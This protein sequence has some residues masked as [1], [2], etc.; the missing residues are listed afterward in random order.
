MNQP[1]PMGSSPHV[2]WINRQCARVRFHG[3]L[4]ERKFSIHKSSLRNVHVE[5]MGIFPNRAL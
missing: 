5:A 2:V 1:P 3:F 4:S